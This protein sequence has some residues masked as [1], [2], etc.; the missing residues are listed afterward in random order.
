IVR[1]RAGVVAARASLWRDAAV[2]KEIAASREEW[3]PLVRKLDWELSYV[4]EREAFPEVASGSP[5]LPGEAW[6]GWDEPYRTTYREYVATQHAK[7]SALHAVRQA[8][9]GADDLAKLDPAWRSAVKLHMATLPLA[10]F[11]AV[12][13]NLRAARFGRD[14]AWRNTAL[15]G[16]LDELRHTQL[17]LL[18]AHDWL[19]KDAQFDWAHRFFHTNDWVAIAGR[20][21]VD[22]LLLT[23]DPIELAIATN[24]VFE[25]G[26][27]NLQFIGLAAVAHQ[28]GDRMFERLLQSIQTDEARHAQIGG[29]VLET[30]IAQDPARA[31]YLVDKWFWRSW[32]FFAVVTGFAM[33]YLTPVEHRRASFKEFVAEWVLDQFERSLAGVGLARPW[34]W[35]RF[36]AALDSYHHMVYAS[37]YTY[38]ATV[39]FDMPLPG[40]SE[41]A[42]LAEKYPRTWPS[43]DPIWQR[44]AD[45]WQTAGPTVE[46]YTHGATPVGFC[47]LCQLVLCN[48]TPERNDARTHVH[49]GR[50]YVFCSEPCQWIFE[51]EPE[52]YAAHR[53]VV[54]HIL[55]GAAPSNLLELLRW[56][57]LD[58]S[59]WGKDTRSGAYPWMGGAR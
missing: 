1:V 29:P 6:R 58:A 59:E 4:D 42:W 34:Y 22:E 16:A 44:L 45:R 19:P 33:D 56:F 32:L 5:W 14:S 41:R 37:A 46:W 15:F 51:H 20:H 53:S 52:R 11:S 36:V 50:R 13:G 31:Q 54:G 7:D 43:F 23:A 12:I 38:R 9:G 48:G 25:T 17:P 49:D 26:F 28:V 40:P 27:T 57:G 24:F 39:W 18:L 2:A 35:D 55:E 3:L 30:V 10:E 8:I 21:F 47:D